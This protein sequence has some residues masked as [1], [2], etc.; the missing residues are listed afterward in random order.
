MDR[1]SLLFAAATIAII[2]PAE[3]GAIDRWEAHIAE[4]AKRFGVPE[5]WIRAVLDAESKGDPRT[6]SPK[7]AMG[8]MQLMPG[9]WQE[10]RVQ[11]NLGADPFDPRANIL[12]GA[13][14]LEA[15]RDRFGY[16]GLFAAYNAG[17]TRYE[18]HLRAGKPLPAET[19]AYVAGLES[20]L[21]GDSGA[22]ARFASRNTNHAGGAARNARVI[23]KSRL[24]F[25]LSTSKTGGEDK[26]SSAPSTEIFAPLSTWKRD[27]N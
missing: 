9:T 5:N 22:S 14:Y 7:G 20:V 2:A 27:D 11:H 4:A 17:P 13:A 10:L 8:L 25:P 26:E 3:A 23:T 1:M 19:R 16:P 15:M 12:A 24:F 18:E 6:V 21:S